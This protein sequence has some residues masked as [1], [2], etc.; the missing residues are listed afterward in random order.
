MKLL[1]RSLIWGVLFS[2]CSLSLAVA[3]NSNNLKQFQSCP[4]LSANGNRF[5]LKPSYVTPKWKNVFARDR[6]K[7]EATAIL[8]R[9]LAAF[10]ENPQSAKLESLK[11]YGTIGNLDGVSLGQMQWNWN[12]GKGTLVREFFK[13]LKEAHLVTDDL[14]LNQQLLIVHRFAKTQIG[15]K[16]ASKVVR[17]WAKLH[18]KQNS[19]LSKWLISTPI[20]KHQDKLVN[21]R[22]N[23]ALTLAKTWLR[24][25]GYSGSQSNNL[26]RVTTLMLNFNIHTGLSPDNTRELWVPQ[27]LDFQSEFSS[28]AE[29]Y[30]FVLEWMKKCE[31]KVKVK[32]SKKTPEMTG[33]EDAFANQHGYPG[34]HK[35]WIT[36]CGLQEISR[37]QFDMFT[38]SF[39]VATRSQTNEFGIR[40]KGFSQ[41]D[42]FNRGALIALGKGIARS[43]WMEIDFFERN[44]RQRKSKWPC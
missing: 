18:G 6:R 31:P 12:G 14:F 41:L 5:D 4:A 13:G 35:L 27:L 43:A 2:T 29:A 22:V 10:Y 24:D 8:A 38:Y 19:S 26:K 32:S 42:V 28:R 36:R 21:D 15:K 7:H 23:Q 17:Q 1:I 37:L 25:M 40:I 44:K 3:S 20:Q 33:G 16:S 9:N 30:K 34:N 11:G 39:L